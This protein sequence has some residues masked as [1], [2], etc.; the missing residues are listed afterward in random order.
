MSSSSSSARNALPSRRSKTGRTQSNAEARLF[1]KAGLLCL[2]WP[3]SPPAPWRRLHGFSRPLY[4]PHLVHPHA[5]AMVALGTAKQQLRLACAKTV[6]ALVQLGKVFLDVA[7][8]RRGFHGGGVA[9]GPVGTFHSILWHDG[10][11]L[12][13][14][15]PCWAC[16]TDVVDPLP[17]CSGAWR[18]M[19][20]SAP[21]SR[22]RR[23]R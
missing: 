12:L 7:A 16:L 20:N 14:R 13:Q 1:E 15:G 8:R 19:L 17:R 18:R 23:D 4:R 21:A 3:R 2:Y 10:C 6:L 11:S 9:A 22:H 5:P